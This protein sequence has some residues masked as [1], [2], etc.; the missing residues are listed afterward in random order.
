MP[1]FPSR[2]HATMLVRA[3][4]SAPVP[5]SASIGIGPTRKRHFPRAEKTVCEE[6][7]RRGTGIAGALGQYAPLQRA[8]REH[9][10]HGCRDGFAIH[11]YPTDGTVWYQAHDPPGYTT[12]GGAMVC[13]VSLPVRPVYRRRVPCGAD[14][15]PDTR[16]EELRQPVR[17]AVYCAPRQETHPDFNLQKAALL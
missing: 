6:S 7:D 12:T 11:I 13:H 16:N 5:R 10:V 8:M 17:T 1:P 9:A 15:L 3:Q 14:E 2:T 4:G